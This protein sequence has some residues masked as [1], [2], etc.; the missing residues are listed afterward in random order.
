VLGVEKASIIADAGARPAHILIRSLRACNSTRTGF[1][2]NTRHVR[3]THML[4]TLSSPSL[5]AWVSKVF[6]RAV[7]AR[8]TLAPALTSWMSRVAESSKA[9]PID[10][11]STSRGAVSIACVATSSFESMRRVVVRAVR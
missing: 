7:Y 10:A 5:D 11:R 4:C 9:S 3:H 2:G 1:N 8:R 6:V